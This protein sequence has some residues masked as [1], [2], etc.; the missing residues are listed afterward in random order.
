MAGLTD[1]FYGIV[2]GYYYSGTPDYKE[3]E[4]AL[5]RYEAIM[6]AVRVDSL[7][8]DGME[9]IEAAIRRLDGRD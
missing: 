6:T 1:K 9:M 7:A 8:S 3:I 2:D 4:K 5:E